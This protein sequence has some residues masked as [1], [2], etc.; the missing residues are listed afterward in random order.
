M[1]MNMTQVIYIILNSSN[2][3]FSPSKYIY[4]MI[5]PTIL[6]KVISSLNANFFLLLIKK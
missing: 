4:K 5:Q 3:K 1:I 6:N 2:P